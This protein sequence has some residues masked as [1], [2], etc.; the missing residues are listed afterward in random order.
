[1]PTREEMM[2][3]KFPDASEISVS[4][5]AKVEIEKRL[6]VVEK[7]SQEKQAGQKKDEAKRIVDEIQYAFTYHPPADEQTAAMI[8]M[9]LEAKQLALLITRNCPPSPDRT[10]A[11]RKVREAVM[12][13]NASIVLGGRSPR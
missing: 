5:E 6:V 7:A 9:R 4:P 1:M 8:D 3:E 11:I 2:P 10:I 13:A 12:Y